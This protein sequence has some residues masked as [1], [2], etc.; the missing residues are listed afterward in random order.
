MISILIIVM[1]VMMIM[2]IKV[3]AGLIGIV[4]VVMIVVVV[5]VGS[6]V[7]MIQEVWRSSSV[8]MIA[9]STATRIVSRSR[10]W[11]RIAERVA[12]K[13]AWIVDER[14]LSSWVA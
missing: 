2:M 14:C 13:V 4:M 3:V 10:I 7:R 6:G 8:S 9:A 11:M 5:V 12:A 1:T